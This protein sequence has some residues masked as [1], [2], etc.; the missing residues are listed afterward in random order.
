MN[1]GHS[2]VAASLPMM[3]NFHCIYT[4]QVS[5]ARFIANVVL[6]S[7]TLLCTV[8]RMCDRNVGLWAAGV[9]GKVPPSL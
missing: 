5:C 3:S 8:C 7:A 6:A 1:S 2:Q 4:C 9:K